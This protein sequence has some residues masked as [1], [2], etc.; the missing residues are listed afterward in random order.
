MIKPLQNAHIFSWI[1]GG[2]NFSDLQCAWK[3]ETPIANGHM[4]YKFLSPWSVAQFKRRDDVA[5]V[6][7]YVLQSK[8][9]RFQLDLLATFQRLS[10][11]KIWT[12]LLVSWFRRAKISPN[13]V[14]ADDQQSRSPLHIAALCQKNLLRQLN[15]HNSRLSFPIL[16]LLSFFLSLTYTYH[17]C[18]STLAVLKMTSGP[19]RSR[20]SAQREP[21][22]TTLFSRMVDSRLGQL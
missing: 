16:F 20:I 10:D 15:L 17:K 9:F 4:T 1:L 6:P 13:R 19:Q 3:A 2:F 14:T 8:E 21:Q 11:S 5:H 7:L 18:W 22:R 12:M